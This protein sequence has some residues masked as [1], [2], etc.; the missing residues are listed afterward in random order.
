MNGTQRQVLT[1]EINKINSEIKALE[2]AATKVF[3]KHS[4]GSLIRSQ[5]KLKERVAQLSEGL[6]EDRSL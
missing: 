6:N 5:T 4:K 3:E 2:N 1:N